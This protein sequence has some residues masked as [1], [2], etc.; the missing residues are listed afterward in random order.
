MNREDAE[1]LIAMSRAFELL[2]KRQKEMIKKFPEIRDLATRIRSV[3]EESVGNSELLSQAVENLNRK[4]FDVHFA[5]NAKDAIK[6]ILELVDSEKVVAK[7]KSNVTKEIKL[8]EELEKR[9]IEVV[10]TDVG[11][12]ILQILNEDP[13]HPTGPAAHLSTA[14]IAR[15]LSEYFGT[16][17]EADAKRI[18]EFLRQDIYGKLRHAEVGITGANA[19]TREGAVVILH[20][21]GNVFEVMN[22]PKRWIVV[23]GIDKL[24]PSIEDAVGAAKLQSFYATGEILPSFVEIVSGHAKTADI[25]KRLV[26]SGTPESISL[27][28]LDNGRGEIADSEFREL[29]YCLGCGSCVANCPAHA[30]YGSKFQGGRFA[31]ADALR[32]DRDIL[33]FCL[34]CRRCRKN[35]PMKIDIPSMISKLREGNEAFNF[36][37]SHAIWLNERLKLEMIKL[38][39][40]LGL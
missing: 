38:T 4:G 26:S 1:K 27:I 11:D 35:C 25:E 31:L 12:R 20:N 40:R 33:K 39:L 19:I 18:V 21:E 9:G 34:S 8:V 5:G 30:V 3:R 22:R 10:E 13:S 16:K 2:R 36:L 37:V 15:K 28:L 6:K 23:T 32:G 29:L 14:T 17:I 7:S 24:Y